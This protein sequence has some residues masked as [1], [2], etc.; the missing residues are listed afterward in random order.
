MKKK[1]IYINL[2][3]GLTK[4]RKKMKCHA[5]SLP[6][7]S[8]LWKCAK[9]MKDS[10]NKLIKKNKRWFRYVCFLV[11]QKERNKKKWY[12]SLYER[13]RKKC[14]YSWWWFFS[15]KMRLFVQKKNIIAFWMTASLVW[16]QGEVPTIRGVAFD[17]W[18][19][20]RP[21]SRSLPRPQQDVCS[22]YLL[23]S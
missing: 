23:A 6:I 13:L 9:M 8:C 17:Q 11:N 14:S 16:V 4:T 2:H 5:I 10:M 12:K 1:K 7:Q 3:F 20:P 15:E 22:S 18:T 19:M 21:L